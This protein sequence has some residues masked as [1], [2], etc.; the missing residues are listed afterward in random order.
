MGRGG[1]YLLSSLGGWVGRLTEEEVVVSSKETT[2]PGH[3][4]VHVH[5]VG[6]EGF[7]DLVEE[8]EEKEEEEEGGWLVSLGG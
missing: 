2:D 7:H 8:K 6:L 3:H 4:A 1:G 5:L